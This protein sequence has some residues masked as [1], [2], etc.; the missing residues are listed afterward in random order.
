MINGVHRSIAKLR[1]VS[2]SKECLSGTSFT[3]LSE[4]SLADAGYGIV[5]R[6]PGPDVYPGRT[7][8]PYQPGKKTLAS[9]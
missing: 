6:N 8:V 7:D 1:Q 4:S 3:V 9:G 2:S 5:N